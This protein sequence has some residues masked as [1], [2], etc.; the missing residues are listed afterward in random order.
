MAT[1]HPQEDPAVRGEQPG[2]VGTSPPPEAENQ[3]TVP[4]GN[5]DLDEQALERSREGLEQAGGGH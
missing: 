5:G 2:V 1:D 4:P 3:S